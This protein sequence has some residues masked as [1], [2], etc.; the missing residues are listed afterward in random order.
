MSSQGKGHNSVPQSPMFIVMV[1]VLTLMV[2]LS[3]CAHQTT[4][5][6]SREKLVQIP[7][8]ISGNG[9]SAEYHFGMAQA[10]SAEGKSDKAIEEYQAAL[11]YD[12]RSALVHTRLAAEFIKKGDLSNALESC[13]AAI[14]ADP[15]YIDARLL[16][17]GLYS[18]TRDS[19]AAMREY[20]AILKFSPW[21][22]ETTIYKSQALLEAGKTEPALKLL[23]DY[24]AHSKDSVLGWYYVGRAEQRSLE[25]KVKLAAPARQAILLRA[26]AAF[27]RAIEIRPRFAQ[28]GLALGL[29]YETEL[30]NDDAM[31]VYRAA[32]DETQDSQIA[33]RL[34]TLLLKAEKYKEAIPYLEGMAS[35]DPE[36]LNVGVKL[37]LVQMEMKNFPRAIEIFKSILTKNPDSDR[38]HYYLGILYEQSK[39]NVAAIEQ[40]KAIQE[41]SKMYSDSVL[42]VAYLYKQSGDLSGARKH[43][44]AAI[45]KSPRNVGFYLFIA[46][47]DEEAKDYVRAA[48]SLERAYQLFPEDEKVLYYLGSMY[49]RIGRVPEALVKMEAILAVNPD[50]PDA[51]NYLGY[52]WTTQGMRLDD[53]EKLLKRAVSLRPLNGYIQDSWGWHLFVRGKTNDAIVQ[54]EKAVRLKPG[55]ATI[56]EHLADAYLRGNLR[57]KAMF[58]YQLAVQ[59]AEDET[60]RRKLDS[61]ID[62][63]RVQIAADQEGRR[64]PGEVR[65]PA[66]EAASSSR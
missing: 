34:T 59:H 7:H 52:T 40:F 54:L 65:Y 24:V 57:Q 58:H 26:V 21:H 42:H 22:E 1:P 2:V 38:I 51:L 16:V 30:K 3:S 29:L 63:L 62:L 10:Y 6:E 49:D 27:R 14:T 53:A 17:A 36:D 19:A 28:A 37:G 18:A 20:D 56:L 23:K 55:E 64:T 33:H 15:K 50:N 5:Q 25:A 11:M 31:E 66:S 35:A 8:K 44:E 9:A 47:A 48:N 41:D 46:S 60:M 43:V 12:S 32:Y 39:E 61:K 13:K 4:V 45:I